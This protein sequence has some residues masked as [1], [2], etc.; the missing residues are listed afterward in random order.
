M[1][2]GG[3]HKD[4]EAVP[5]NSPKSRPLQKNLAG[6]HSHQNSPKFDFVIFFWVQ[7]RP[8]SNRNPCGKVFDIRIMTWFFSRGR[9]AQIEPA[10]S[11]FCKGGFCMEGVLMVSA[12]RCPRRI[13]WLM[14]LNLLHNGAFKVCS[15]SSNSSLPARVRHSCI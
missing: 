10:R 14:T 15:K 8:E 7:M 3:S 6:D 5:Q 12:L 9:W 11:N 2:C 1:A 13:G 4:A